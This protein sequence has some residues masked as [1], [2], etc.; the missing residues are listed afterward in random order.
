MTRSMMGLA[1]AAFLA[2]GLIAVPAYG[3]SAADKRMADKLPG[4]LHVY[5]NNDAKLFTQDGITKAETAFSNTHFNHGLTLTIDLYD[6]GRR[7][8][9]M[10]P[11]RKS[12]SMTGRLN[13]QN[14]TKRRAS[15][16]S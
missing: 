16:S 13:G 14:Q 4:V 7:F 5:G 1:I 9:R 15:M 3:S 6:K 11:A 10:K 8:P 2:C 12:S